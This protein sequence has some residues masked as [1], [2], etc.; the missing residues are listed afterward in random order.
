MTCNGASYEQMRAT[1]DMT[2]EEIKAH[3][4]PPFPNPHTLRYTTHT[5]TLSPS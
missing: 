4:T 5:H 2:L 3:D 1:Y